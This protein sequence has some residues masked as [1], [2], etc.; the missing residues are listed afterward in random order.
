MKRKKARSDT[1]LK[2]PPAPIQDAATGG[3][4]SSVASSQQSSIRAYVRPNF[5]KSSLSPDKGH[6]IIVAQIEMFLC[7]FDSPVGVNLPVSVHAL[8]TS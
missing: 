5:L 3:G 6:A 2:D 4:A 7:F 8:L 1:S